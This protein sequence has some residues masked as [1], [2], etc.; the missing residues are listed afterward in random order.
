M[1]P[2]VQGT[3]RIVCVATRRS[4]VAKV[5]YVQ[6]GLSVFTDTWMPC[7]TT[8]WEFDLEI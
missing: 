2:C 7:P 1:R 6:R 8:A 3:S 5:L 4:V